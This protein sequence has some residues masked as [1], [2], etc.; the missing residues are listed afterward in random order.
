MTRVLPRTKFHSSRLIRH[1]ADLAVVDAVEPGDGFAERLGQWVHFTDAIV[2]SD[3]LNDSIAT[4]SK[5]DRDAVAA[6]HAAVAA[7]FDRTRTGLANSI[8]KSFSPKLGKAHIE[9]PVPAF[10]LPIN[11]AAAY[12]PYR[13]FYDAHQRDMELGIE[14]LR[15]NVREALATI[16]PEMKKLAELDATFERALS[17]RENKLLSSV[18]LLLKKRFEQLFNAHQQTVAETRQSD[19]PADWTQAGA[20]L[21]RFY[22]DLQGLLLAELE[23]RLQPTVGLIETLNTSFSESPGESLIG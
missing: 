2:L 23:F 20:W 6:A 5:A 21:A 10:E 19:N 14:P 1:L 8:M 3:V 16:S 22:G 4:K 12:L 15:V 17:V 9:L 7:Q 11:I 18:P 13:R